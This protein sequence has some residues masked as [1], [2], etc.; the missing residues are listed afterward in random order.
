MSDRAP[1]LIS[2]YSIRGITGILKAKAM[3][4]WT[5]NE[6]R[7]LRVS[8]LIFNALLLM[9]SNKLL[10]AVAGDTVLHEKGIS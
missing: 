7:V 5:T 4:V 9:M 8:S 10:E 2:P 3:P 1:M 6:N